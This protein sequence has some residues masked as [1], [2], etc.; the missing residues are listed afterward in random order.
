[1]IEVKDMTKLYRR[2]SE[3]VHAA[4]DINIDI[5]RGER[6]YI[7][8]PSGAGKTTLLHI[9][10]GLSRP[11]TGSVKFAEDDLY[12]LS[13]RKRSI[14]RNQHYGFIFQF[15]HL[16]PELNVLEN[17]MLP[18]LMKGGE[19]RSVIKA[20]ASELLKKVKLDHRSKHRPGELSGG[21][22]QRTAIA[23]ALINAPQVLF[24]DEPTGNLDSEMSDEIYRLILDISR[25]NNMAVVVVSHQ[26][27]IENF[28]DSEYFM[29]DGA[30]EK[31]SD[32]QHVNMTE[33]VT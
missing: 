28:S 8:G 27:I 20:K 31:V 12:R 21:E 3:I 19:R 10:G 11:S 22:A 30:L 16:L 5:R 33:T 25:E 29:K 32:S 6:I 13:D 7:H 4:R 24:C 14:V 26:D 9:L 17:I 18:A 1:M 15:Y 2:G 23:R